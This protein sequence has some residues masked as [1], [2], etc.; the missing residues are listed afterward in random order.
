MKVVAR[1]VRVGKVP[2][3]RAAVLVDMA[4]AIE[5][6]T[7]VVTGAPVPVATAAWKGLP[8]SISTN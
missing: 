2:V 5:A 6:A 4:G 8:R 7:E 3:G 1:P